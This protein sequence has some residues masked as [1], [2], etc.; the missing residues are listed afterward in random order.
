MKREGF[1]LFALM[2]IILIAFVAMVGA[3]INEH[4]ENRKN[5]KVVIDNCEKT[6]IYSIDE[7]GVISPAYDCSNYEL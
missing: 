5:S 3:L 4:S 2:G 1:I 6:A 7:Y